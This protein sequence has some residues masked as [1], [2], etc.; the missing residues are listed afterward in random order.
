MRKSGMVCECGWNSH[1]KRLKTLSKSHNKALH[2]GVNISRPTFRPVAR[3]TRRKMEHKMRQP[4]AKKNFG[5][6]IASFLLGGALLAVTS[7]ANA[8][9]GPPTPEGLPTEPVAQPKPEVTPVGDWARQCIQPEGR[10]KRCILSQG[11]AAEG[12]ER[13]LADISISYIGGQQPA[14]Q[15]TVPLGIRLPAGLSY[16]I[17]GNQG[18]RAPFIHCLPIGWQAIF[19]LDKELISK[20]QKGAKGEMIFQNLQGQ[21]VGI[22]TS[23]SGFTAGFKSLTE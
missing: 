1:N 15:V 23:L 21:N 8:Q 9:V 12:A 18:S 20:M 6:H 5:H 10:L 4:N 2:K 11:V 19:P 14:M 7:A 13:P 22:P 16:K 17:D 3:D